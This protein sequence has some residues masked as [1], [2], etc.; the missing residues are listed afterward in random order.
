[1]SYI[2]WAHKRSSTPHVPVV[3]ASRI[4]QPKNK[5]VKRRVYNDP[6]IFVPKASMRSI[7]EEVSRARGISIAMMHGDNRHRPAVYARQEAWWRIR[8]ELGYSYPR[9]AKA[10][11]KDHSTIVY[12][13][14]RHEER[15]REAAKG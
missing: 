12:G 5:P 3:P 9:I 6:P 11:D 2:D 8:V 1:M 7:T 4:P 10:F 14:R 15:M 13:V